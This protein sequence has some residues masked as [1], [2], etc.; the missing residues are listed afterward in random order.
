MEYLPFGEVWIED[1]D[2]AT[3]YIPFRFTSKELDRETD[4]YYYDVRYYE[5]KVSRWMSADPAR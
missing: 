4:L 2:A 5:P 1:V 3:R